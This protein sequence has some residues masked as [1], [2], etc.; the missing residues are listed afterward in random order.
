MRPFGLQPSIRA[1]LAAPLLT[2][3]ASAACAAERQTIGLLEAAAAALNATL[4]ARVAE[5]ARLR[6]WSG[7]AAGPTLGALAVRHCCNAP[8]RLA[9]ARGCGC[10][11][12]PAAHTPHICV[13]AWLCLRWLGS[14]QVAVLHG[15][16]VASCAACGRSDA[17]CSAAAHACCAALWCAQ[18]TAVCSRPRA[19]ARGAAPCGRGA[20]RA[21]RAARGRAAPARCGTARCVARCSAVRCSCCALHVA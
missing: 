9:V 1:E 15:W 5:V 17:R 16:R 3:T 7:V 10:L 8:T 21:H 4:A 18:C 20:G 11:T 6:H 19:A 14:T 12:R 2:A 13:V